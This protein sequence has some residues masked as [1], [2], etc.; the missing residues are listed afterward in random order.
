MAQNELNFPV[1]PHKHWLI[2]SFYILYFLAH[3]APIFFS[4]ILSRKVD[5]RPHPYCPSLMVLTQRL[6]G[7]L[8]RM[9][10]AKGRSHHIKIII[11]FQLNHLIRPPLG[12]T[13]HANG[14]LFLENRTV[15]GRFR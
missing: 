13:S 15:N 2:K 3:L 11:W 6:L 10:L 12:L 14:R 7:D 4:I 8:L 9:G 5:Q 1:S